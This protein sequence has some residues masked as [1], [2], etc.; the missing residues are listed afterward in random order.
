MRHKRPVVGHFSFAGRTISRTGRSHVATMQPPPPLQP[1]MQASMK[2]PSPLLTPEQQPLKPTTPLQPLMQ[3]NVKPPS[4][5]L[6]PE[7]RP[8]KPPTPLQPENA[9][10]TPISHPQRRRRFQLRLSLRE[11]RC[12]R[13]QPH[14]R[15]SEQRRWWFHLRLALREQRRRRFHSRDFQCPRAMP[16]PNQ[17][18][19]ACNSPTHTSCCEHVIVE[20]P[21][22]LRSHGLQASGNCMRNCQAIAPSPV[23]AE[24][25]GGTGG[26]GC[27]T[28]GRRRGR[29]AGGP[30][31]TGA[32]SSPAPQGT[33][34]PAI[35]G[36]Q[37]PSGSPTR[38]RHPPGRAGAPNRRR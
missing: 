36:S 37:A 34:R 3:T 1:L 35:S 8:L 32:Q 25:A 2:P 24:G 9:S 6:A 17:R 15:T 10:K 5:M 21:G 19:F 30:P 22:F 27:G 31:P 4:P 33:A 38:W 20:I 18:T 29:R 11:Q 13:F 16:R 26:P 14:T 12:H 28:R 7:Q 23:G